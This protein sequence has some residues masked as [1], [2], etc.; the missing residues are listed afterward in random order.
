MP[1]SGNRKVLTYYRRFPDSMSVT[2]DAKHI[3]SFLT[4]KFVSKKKQDKSPPPTT[5]DTV[6]TFDIQGVS[7]HPNHRSLYHGA[8]AFV[9]A[10]MRPY[11]GWDSPIQVY[12]LRSTTVLRK[13]L[14]ILDAPITILDIIFTRKEA[15]SNPTPLLFVSGM[16]QYRN[17]QQAMTTAHKSQMVWFRWGWITM[18][19]YM[20]LNDLRREKI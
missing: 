1:K 6:I 14:S 9:K 10:L 3:V 15:G 2:W 20:I 5:I 8:R 11:A 7:L 13:Y 12:T 19:R 18:S 17:A 4:S 16:L